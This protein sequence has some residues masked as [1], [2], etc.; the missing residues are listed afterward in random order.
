[1]RDGTRALK[2]QEADLTLW[3]GGG[4][5]EMEEETS[6]GPAAKEDKMNL[7]VS[8]AL[9]QGMLKMPKG[10]VSAK[11]DQEREAFSLVSVAAKRSVAMLLERGLVKTVGPEVVMFLSAPGVQQ[12]GGRA[13]QRNDEANVI[14]CLVSWKEK[15]RLQGRKRIA[16]GRLLRVRRLSRRLW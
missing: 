11:K 10:K 5:L 2:G 7:V 15:G 1:M 8:D 3:S 16:R 9:Y 4:C 12:A 14:D 13:G 6:P